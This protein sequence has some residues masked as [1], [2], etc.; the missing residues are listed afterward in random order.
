MMLVRMMPTTVASVYLR[1]SFILGYEFDGLKLFLSYRGTNLAFIGEINKIFAEKV[2]CQ[3][4]GAIPKA[5]SK[6]TA[7]GDCRRSTRRL[8]TQ[9]AEIANAARGD[10]QR[11]L[12]DG[13]STARPY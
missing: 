13:T 11:F 4:S 12:N 2:I 9:H 8:S 10:C 1:K 3:C 7:R 5:L 6:N